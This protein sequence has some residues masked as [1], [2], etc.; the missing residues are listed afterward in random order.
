M[1]YLFIFMMIKEIKD[2]FCKRLNSLFYIINNR[3]II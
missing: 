1:I 2:K 3:P